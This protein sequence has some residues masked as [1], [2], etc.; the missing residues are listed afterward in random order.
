MT[1]KYLLS[2]II[3]L[4]LLT[5][6]VSVDENYSLSVE[7]TISAITPNPTSTSLPTYT[8]E[9]TF[10]PYPTFTPQF[11]LTP[12]PTLTPN[13]VFATPTVFLPSSTPFD[14]II[15]QMNKMI[16]CGEDFYINV[17]E[18]IQE[19]S[20]GEESTPD[21]GIFLVIRLEITNN[22]SSTI[23]GIDSD[24]F[25]IEGIRTSGTYEYFP[26]TWY[27][28]YMNHGISLEAVGKVPWDEKTQY[29]PFIAV[30]S[31]LVFDIHNDISELTFV[32]APD[33]YSSCEVT[34]PLQ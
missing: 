6:C 12:L 7:K 4:F 8:P 21:N 15:F 13:F 11:T 18:Q 34:I 23:S 26:D 9:A 32:F 5:H 25:Q 22:T 14:E 33:Q 1:N 3:L 27:T 29:T 24:S 16:P 31:V 20:F 28:W 17:Y 19:I 2:S 10:S 30:K